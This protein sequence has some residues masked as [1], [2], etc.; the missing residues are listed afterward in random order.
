MNEI[1]VY[2]NTTVADV[3]VSTQVATV[4]LGYS[5]PQGIGQTQ[6][7]D[8]KDADNA[9]IVKGAVY[10]LTGSDG[11]NVTVRKA[12]GNSEATSSNTIGVAIASSV[13]GAKASLATSGTIYDI[14]TSTLTEGQSVYLSPTVAGGLTTTKPSA[15]NHAV[16][17]GRCIR[18][19][20]INGV[21]FVAIRNG[22]ELEELHN[23]AITNP[24]DK[25]V[26]QYDAAVDLWENYTLGTWTSFTPTVSG[27]GWDIGNGT[28]SAA[29]TRIGNTV[30]YRCV[31]TFGSTSTYG[32][33]AGVRLS[34]PYS[35]TGGPGVTTCLLF[36]SSA[37]K[38]YLGSAYS[39]AADTLVLQTQGTA[40]ILSSVT[41]AA[42]FTW[43]T[44]DKLFLYGS[45]QAVAL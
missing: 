36:D 1:T 5:A 3:T 2:V 45:Y 10:Y 29:Y 6:L 7:L 19:H 15:P 8:A 13:G 41:S 39:V 4:E 33:A 34:L 20:A 31:A 37:A 27:T 21:L 26:L 18:Q 42:P 44:G 17:I 24:V 22:W 38:Y 28:F 30:L 16:I 9:G 12:L 32:A 11:S 25:Q 43:D 40:G 14:D 23:V 35:S